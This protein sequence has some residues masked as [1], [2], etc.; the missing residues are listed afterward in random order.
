MT[1]TDVTGTGVT[2]TDMT[3]AGVTAVERLY[4]I[5]EQ[6]LCIGCGICQSVAGADSVAVVKTESGYQ[7]P[8]VVGELSHETVDTIYD[9]CPGTRVD[10]LP[11]RLIAGDTSVDKVWGPWRRMT[12]AWASDPDVRHEGS[13]GGVLTALAQYLLHSERVDFVLHV[14]ASTTEPTFGESTLSFTQ[15]DVLEAA[16]SRYGPTPPLLDINAV[17]DRGQ[18]FAFVGKPCDLNA[19]RN[20]ARH[21]SRVD[22]LVRYW[23]T[24]VCGGYGTPDF[25]AKFLNRMGVDPAELTGF[26]YRGRGCPGPTTAT[27]ADGSVDAHYL[28]YWGDDASMWT[29]PWR[30]KICPDGIGESAD[31]AAADSWPGGS[32]TRE[33]S[34]TDLGVNAVIARTIAG[35]ELLEAAVGDGFITVE[36]DI[37]PDDMNDYQPHQVRKKY[38]VAPRLAGIAAE[39]RIKPKVTGLR[40]DELAAE[41]PVEVNEQQIAGARERIRIGKATLPTPVASGADKCH[42]PV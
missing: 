1:A 31:I 20:W 37:T 13:T 28:D 41:V 16:G 6:G 19:L 35:Q 17:L 22:E 30:C 21:D 34:E 18:P 42:T 14:K 9:V 12:R 23:L 11:E 2:A 3:A 32:P 15:A 40:V 36:H 24:M 4:A 8:V 38:A 27:T 33:G 5:V 7:Q 25:T 29:L 10:G 39:G 26:R